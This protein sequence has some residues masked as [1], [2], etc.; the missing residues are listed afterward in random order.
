MGKWHLGQREAY[1][2]GSRGFDSYLGIPYSDDMGKGRATPCAK[3]G[4]SAPP[5]GSSAASARGAAL[6]GGRVDVSAEGGLRQL[7]APYVES[8]LAAPLADGEV[9]DP[10]GNFLPLVRQDGRKTTVLEQ[11]LDLTTLAQKYTDFAT[12][13]IDEHAAEPFFL[14]MPFSHVHTTADDQPDKQYAGCASKNATSRGAF[15]DAL[16]EVDGTVAAVMAKL[17]ERNLDKNTL[18]LFTGDNGPWM[19]QGRSGGS[20]GLLSGRFAGYWN[21][22]KGSTW[23]GG[24]REAGFAH[25]PGTIRP[26]TRSAEVVSSMDVFPTALELAGVPLPADRA[27]DGRSMLGVL[28]NESSSAHEVLFFYGGVNGAAKPSA[29]RYGPFKAHWATGPGLSGCTPGPGAPV[30]CP[31]KHYPDVPLLF[32]VA[33]DPSEAY[34]LTENNTM[35]T[36]P[37]LRAVVAFLQAAYAEEVA[38]LNAYTAPPA[39]DGPGEGAGKYGVCCDRKKGCDCDGKPSA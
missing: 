35:P 38:S 20:T 4:M 8:G 7:L 16:A 29:A 33:V 32:N 27:Y 12:G 23:E 30:G 15:G 25:W 18:V 11:P 36:D 10:A 24:I 2:P 3:S 22:G 14:Y 37:N 26:F 39:P 1:L 19:V 5:G 28:L 31:K 34:A 17:R 21:T 9:D 13:F 6:E